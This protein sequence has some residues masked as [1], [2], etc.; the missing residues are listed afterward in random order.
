MNKPTLIHIKTHQ[1]VKIGDIVQ[2]SQD[3]RQYRILNFEQ[4]HKPSSC[5]KILVEAYSPPIEYY[6]SVFGLEWIN[7]TDR[8]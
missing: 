2:A 5:G 8:D 3:D 7:R 4:P 6:V 1:P